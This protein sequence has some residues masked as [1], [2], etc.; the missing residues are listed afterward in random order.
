MKSVCAESPSG[1][2]SIAAA[3]I[4]NIAEYIPKQV[5]H[6]AVRAGKMVFV[7]ALTSILEIFRSC[8]AL[9]KGGMAELVVQLPIIVVT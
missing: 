7:E 3:M 2:A 5:V 9:F 4:E 6:I 1:K 8:T